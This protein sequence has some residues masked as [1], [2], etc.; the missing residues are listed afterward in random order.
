[1]RVIRMTVAAAALAAAT[2][3]TGT[4]L[5]GKPS[6]GGGGGSTGGGTIWFVTNDGAYT[7]NS[8]GSGKTI[9]PTVWGL[10]SRG[11]E[12]TTHGGHR[13]FLRRHP[14]SGAQYDPKRSQQEYFAVRDDG[15]MNV[16]LTDQADL[17][18]L[19]PQQTDAHWTPDGLALSWVARRW[20]GAV[21]DG[22]VVVDRGVYVAPLPLQVVR[23]IAGLAAQPPAPPRRIPLVVAGGSG[24]GVTPDVF[25]FS[26]SP[27]ATR[28]VYDMLTLHDTSNARTGVVDL[29]AGTDRFLVAGSR[30][31]WSPDGG[32]ILWYEAGHRN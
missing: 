27:D 25:S 21:L 17:D 20:N 24:G 19:V 29:V 7:M 1:M 28:F 26:W 6:A 16:Q 4:A 11:Y 13:W 15:A 30:P 23:N 2:I 32:R 22:G 12:F 8:D 14:V 10:G 3:A 31:A 18:L 5:A 9:A